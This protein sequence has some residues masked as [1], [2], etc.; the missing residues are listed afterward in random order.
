LLLLGALIFAATAG[1]WYAPVLL[2]HGGEFLREFFLAHHIQRFFTNKYRHPQPFYFFF[3]IALMGSFPWSIYLVAGAARAVK[4]RRALVS[5]PAHRLRLFLWLWVLVPVTFFSF[6]TSKLPGYILPIFPAVALLIGGELERWWTEAPSKRLTGSGVLTAMLLM[7]VALGVGWQGSEELGVSARASWVAAALALAA[8]GIYLG[9]L[10]RRRGRAATLWL[11]FGLT[12]VVFASVHL[13]LPGLGQ[14][15][16]MRELSQAATRAARPGERLAFYI[17]NEQS[18]NFYAPALP[19]RDARGELRT[20]MSPTEIA[21]LLEVQPTPS[22]LVITPER[23]SAD[24]IYDEQMDAKKLGEQRELVL[25]RVW[26][27]QG[28]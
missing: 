10:L 6:S 3:A 20:A 21:A 18:I 25:L 5:D 27:R 26:L 8:A 14:R 2:R 24:L 12:A 28:Q 7:I 1:V 13:L 23:W 4:Q 9:L 19:L 17:N 22:L 16:S 11:P 15:E